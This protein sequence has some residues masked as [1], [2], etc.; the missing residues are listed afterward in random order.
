G[1]AD[2]ELPFHALMQPPD[3]EVLRAPGHR[4]GFAAG[5]ERQFPTA[6]LQQLQTAAVEGIETLES[7]ARLAEMK[8]AVGQHAFDVLRRQADVA[9]PREC[10]C[11][12]HA[13]TTFA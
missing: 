5:N 2:L 4:F 6:I 9:R 13:Q 10:L 7:P 8:R 11:P 1:I 3:A 12:V